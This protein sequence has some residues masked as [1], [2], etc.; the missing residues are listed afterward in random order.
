MAHGL[1]AWL[2]LVLAVMAAGMLAWLTAPF[3][4]NASV[5]G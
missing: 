5:F 1:A 4:K 3:K 2:A